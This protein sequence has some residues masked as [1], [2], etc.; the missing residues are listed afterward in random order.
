MNED[1][2]LK[3]IK[4][5]DITPLKTNPDTENYNSKIQE[6][7]LIMKNA[8]FRGNFTNTIFNCIN[9]PFYG[10]VSTGEFIIGKE[11]SYSRWSI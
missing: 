5:I 4:L 2:P 1:N 3:G 10:C 7:Y 8:I 6:K 11:F 9:G